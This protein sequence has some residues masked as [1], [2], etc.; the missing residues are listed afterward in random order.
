MSRP[1][2]DA[3]WESVEGRDVP[4]DNRGQTRGSERKQITL[5]VRVISDQP[6]DLPGPAEVSHVFG[7]EGASG[8]TRTTVLSRGKGASACKICTDAW[9][10]PVSN[11]R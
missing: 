1:E 3:V 11:S 5:R 10:V 2:P 9:R 6:A 4:E 8:R 7:N